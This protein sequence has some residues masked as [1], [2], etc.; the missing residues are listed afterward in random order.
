MKANAP[1]NE[2]DAILAKIEGVEIKNVLPN[3][4]WFAVERAV[5]MVG[6]TANTEV[7]AL[8][9]IVETNEAQL[10]VHSEPSDPNDID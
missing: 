4:R 6:V 2:V 9:D 10:A 1:Q 3:E 8:L 5:R 7:E